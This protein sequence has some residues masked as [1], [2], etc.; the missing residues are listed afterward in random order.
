MGKGYFPRDVDRD[1]VEQ[2]TFARP[3]S[4]RIC[5]LPLLYCNLLSISTALDN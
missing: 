1:E 5:T 2:I 4:Y 3:I